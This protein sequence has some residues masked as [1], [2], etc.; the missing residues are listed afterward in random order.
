[1]DKI[2]EQIEELKK[3]MQGAKSHIGC[4][5]LQRQIETLEQK[6]KKGDGGNWIYA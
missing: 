3:K 4:I 6:K 5:E 1:M 2:D